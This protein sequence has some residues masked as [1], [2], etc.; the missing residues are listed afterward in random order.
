MSI[1][2]ESIKRVM[3]IEGR[4]ADKFSIILTASNDARAIHCISCGKF[5]LYHQHRILAV[6]EDDMSHVLHAAPFQIQCHHCGNI[7]ELLVI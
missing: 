3:R 5:M 6:V 2:T 1:R 7:M 4:V